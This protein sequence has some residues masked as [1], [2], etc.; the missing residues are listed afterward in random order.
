V[1]AISGSL[2]YNHPIV[3][4]FL[5]ALILALNL[6]AAGREVAIT[7]D[8]LPRGGGD[9]G[10]SDLASVR[11]MTAKLLA[12]FR[13]QK[14]PVIGFVNAGRNNLGPQGL[15]QILDLWLDAGADLGNHSYSHLNINDVGLAKYT[16]DIVK[17]EPA[18]RAALA[19][20]GK[21][22][23]FYRHPFL[24]TGQT[25][26]VKTALQVFLD[27]HHYRVAPV[28]LDNNDWEFASLYNQPEYKDRVARGYV[29]YMESTVAFF[30][31]RSVEVVGREIPQI[32]LIHASHMNAD[33]MPELLAMFRRRGYT[34][35]SLEHALA[36]KA[37]SLPDTHT[38][39][40]GVSWI[41]RWAADKGMPRKDEPD[42]P[43]WVKDAR[44]RDPYR[45][46]PQTYHLAFENQWVRATRVTFNPHD[47]L[48]VHHHPPTPT[49]LY[50]YV[51][52][53]GA[54]RFNHVT[55]EHVAG[56]NIERKPVQAG[57]IRF[58]HGAPETHTVDYLGDQPSEYARIELRTE[59]LER[60]VR[61]IRLPPHGSFENAQ[62]RILSITC[63]ADT[64]CPA[65]EH[66]SDPAVVVILSGPHRGEIQWSPSPAVGPLDLVRLEL[67]TK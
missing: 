60:P 19:A 49:T 21:K 8:D 65:S 20:H 34:F 31:Q 3:M 32:L 63:A 43:Q 66:P 52:D 15:R 17:G 50:V 37:Y 2:F 55:G 58:A 14:I 61:D 28:T 22:L 18:I 38:F 51:T 36:D 12:P 44:S 41:H 33:L 46:A 64:P 57:Q 24:F 13:E 53:G 5:I 25:A 48:P 29:P 40:N 27:Q 54:I 4:K 9:A 23:I 67:K 35:V 7:I 26:P 59:P 39:N 10:P 45:V 30:E 42:S 56:M 47:H 11:A 62:V 6:S 1:S 16:A